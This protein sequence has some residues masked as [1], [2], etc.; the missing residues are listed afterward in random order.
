MA[1]C[2]K[3]RGRVS[4]R[5]AYCKSCGERLDKQ[6][7]HDI[8]RVC[9]FCEGTGDDPGDGS[10]MV[11]PSVCRVCKGAKGG[12]FS[13]ESRRCKGECRGNGRIEVTTGIDIVPNFKPCRDCGGW[14][15]ADP[16]K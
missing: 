2:P 6:E 9:E 1:Y 3:C 7:H 16:R 11:V 12:Y 8:R 13:E 10:L 15:W 5:D 14:G 4:V